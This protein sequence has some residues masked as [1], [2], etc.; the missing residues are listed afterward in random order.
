MRVNRALRFRY[1][2]IAS[3]LL[4]VALVSVSAAAQSPAP[5]FTAI[6]LSGE[7]FTNDSL[8]GSVV[9]LQFWATWCPHCREDQSSLDNIDRSFATQGLVVLA[10]NAGEPEATVTEYLER[11]PRSCRIVLAQDTDLLSKFPPHGYP[12]YVAIN[13]EGEVAG[14]QAG[15]GGESALRHL[16]R[17][18]GLGKA[19]ADLP[20]RSGRLTPTQ[21]GES[22]PRLINVPGSSRPAAPPKAQGPALFLFKN[23]DRLEAN[24]YM[25][26]ASSLVATIDGKQRTFPLSALD[27]KATLEADRVRG[28]DIKVPSGAGDVFLGP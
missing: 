8:R 12:Y 23:G 27:V 4:L 15:A 7:Q 11:H 18:A 2:P 13:R 21:A 1:H 14:T 19:P 3:T 10:V 6:T 25:L 9:L 17:R 16:L 5:Q 26:T 24:H 28:I 20:S 22:A